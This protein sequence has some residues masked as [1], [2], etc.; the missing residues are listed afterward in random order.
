MKEL[1]D[2]QTKEIEDKIINMI[3]LNRIFFNEVRLSTTKIAKERFEAIKQEAHEDLLRL[4]EDTQDESAT[5]LIR[6][7]AQA[8]KTDIDT[9]LSWVGFT[10]LDELRGYEELKE[11]NRMEMRLQAISRPL[12]QQLSRTGAK[13]MGDLINHGLEH[14]FIKNLK[15]SNVHVNPEPTTS[16]PSHNEIVTLDNNSNPSLSDD[17]AFA[18]DENA[19][20]HNTPIVNQNRLANTQSTLTHSQSVS[21]PNLTSCYPIHS[22]C[23]E[24]FENSH[25]QPRLNKV[26]GS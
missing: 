9:V 24:Y 6:A 16:V 3:T 13:F 26:K 1:K 20:T 8:L 18:D 2:I 21:S 5:L 25:C 12:D 19:N 7:Q 22:T 4:K 23:A 17:D 10:S 15:K 11:Y 14:G